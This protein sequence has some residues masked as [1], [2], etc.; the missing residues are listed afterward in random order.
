MKLIEKRW[1]T[2]R[3]VKGHA[4]DQCNTRADRLAVQGRDKR[5]KE[6]CVKIAMKIKAGR[7]LRYFEVDRFH[8]N[9]L[10]S[11]ENMWPQLQAAA[12]VSLGR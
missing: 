4:G 2:L 8:L 3:R 11:P 10:D 7:Y 6:V 12:P 5:A 1:I 9:L